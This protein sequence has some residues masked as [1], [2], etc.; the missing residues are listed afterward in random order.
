MQ[1]R[2]HWQFRDQASSFNGY[3]PALFKLRESL[4]TKSICDRLL[5][6]YI[7]NFEKTLRILH[8]PTFRRLYTDYW[9]R[10]NQPVDTLPAFLPQLT[11]ILAISRVLDDRYSQTG[12]LSAR[13]YLKQAALDLVEAWL[14]ELGRKERSELSTLQVET[15]LLL[16]KQLRIDHAEKLWMMAG[17]LVRSAMA[18]GLHLDPSRSDKISF[19]QA[20][21]RRR[22]WITIVEMDIQASI[23]S[24]MPLMAPECDYSSLTPNNIHD[25]DYDET[26]K[27]LPPFRP[28][29]ETTD[30][31]SQIAL[32]TSMP[33]RIRILSLMQDTTV[34]K[35]LDEVIKEGSHLEELLKSIP[36]PLRLSNNKDPHCSAGDFLNRVLLDVLMRRML[37]TLYRPFLVSEHQLDPSFDRIR[38]KCL[39]SALAILSYQ[40]YFDPEVADLDAFALTSLYWNIFQIFCRDDIRWAALGVCQ[41]IKTF[42]Q[43]V[44]TPATDG[45]SPA[46]GRHLAITQTPNGCAA[47]SI[48]T[49][50]SLIRLVENTIDGLI[51]SVVLPGSSLKDIAFL[52]VLLRLVRGA[53]SSGE[54]KEKL[55]YE[56]SKKVLVACRQILT[57]QLAVESGER[58][59]ENN[60]DTGNDL[61]R[62]KEGMEGAMAV[63]FSAALRS[64]AA[65]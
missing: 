18:I 17:A 3:S 43:S 32:A 61:G 36:P 24:G 57:Q 11:S 44:P 23:A 15:L 37:I 50:G 49:K 33:Q 22:L 38:S 16:A 53:R 20:E 14:N 64:C 52:V 19:Y 29:T 9:T 4:P 62:R 1:V 28:L 12:D 55:M 25:S 48:P 41:Y 42:T 56:D 63:S 34:S 13:T 45:T 51:R 7:E 10:E 21:N 30:S 39:E 8:L 60:G 65:F 54:Q 5:E 59:G 6:T 46:S 47:D 31:L 27:E 26:T 2:A 35:S 58:N 40:D